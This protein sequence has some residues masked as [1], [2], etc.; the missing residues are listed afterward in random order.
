MTDTHGLI[1]R[2]R[3]LKKLIAF[4]DTDFVKTVT[5]IRRC[6][7]SCLFKLMIQYLKTQGIADEQIIAMNCEPPFFSM[8]AGDFYAYVKERIIPG[9]RM[10]MFFDEVQRVQ[11]WADAVNS[12]QADFDCDIYIAG[13]NAYLP[14]S[15]YA[16]GLAGRCIEVRMLPLS[17][18]EFMDFHGFKLCESKS[19]L[20]GTRKR[21][22]AGDGSRYELPEVF[23]A[24]LR[25]GGMPVIADLRL[26]RDKAWVLLDGICA[27]VVLRDILD[28]EDRL[29]QQ[30]RIADPV[31]LKKII[32]FLT[33][34]IGRGIS[35]SQAGRALM[36]EGLTA[37][38]A[39]A[40]A[41]DLRTVRS[42]VDALLKAYLFYEVKRYDLKGRQFLK[43]Q[44]KY[45]IADLG[46]KNCLQG[47]GNPD[48]G[49]ALENI[50]YF[51]LLRRGYDVAAG[52]IGNGEIDFI[53]TSADHKLYIQVTETM[54]GEDVRKREL[55]PLQ[56]IRDNHEKLVLSLEPGF[57]RDY[58]GIK[59]LNLVDW[60]IAS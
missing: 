25:F 17:F 15:A 10:Y 37:G 31:L 59:S 1:A 38:N 24:F 52:K 7:K 34:N 40:R 43:T 16:S 8:T 27:S 9:M 51:E 42:Y 4:K 47:F 22:V 50:V 33:D 57:E 13:S 58:D 20:G 18:R 29:P 53:A 45:Y 23:A 55:A 3:Y 49:Q 35:W 12:F 2:D 21:A 54:V 32:L 39:R 6:G 26:D 5:G 28:R 56:K 48:S 14:G 36:Q 41:P 11:G 19:A 44:G 60:L 46:L 30:K